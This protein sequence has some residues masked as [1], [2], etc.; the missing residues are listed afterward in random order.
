MNLLSR[1]RHKYKSG[2]R[3]SAWLG[4]ALAALVLALPWA[5]AAGEPTLER[6][7]VPGEI[8]VGYAPGAE[9]YSA[10][11]VRIAGVG[12]NLGYHPTLHAFHVR[13]HPGVSIETALAQMRRQPGVLYA[14]PV[15]VLHALA[16][17]NDPSFGSQWAPTKIQANLAW[18]I[19]QP[20]ASVVI[21]MVDSGVDGTHPDLVNK[22]YRDANGIVGYNAFQ[23]A[24]STAADDNGHGTHCA[25]IAAAQA[26][27]GIGIAGI[28]GWNGV[29][30]VSDT[31]HI[32]IMPIKAL[33]S[34]GSGTDVTAANGI[35]WAANNGAKVISMS[36]GMSSYSQTL[37]NACQFAISKGCVVVA[38]AGNNGSNALFYPA[39]DANVISV[40]ATDSTDTLASFS[41]YG[42]W[43]SVA[44]PGN[45]IYSTTP[46]YATSWPLNY[47]YGSGTSMATPHVAGEAALLLA[48]NPT[49]TPAQVAALIT[50]NVDPCKAYGTHAL[51]AAAGR[52][53]VYRALQAAAG[54]SSSVPAAPTGL[55]ATA[56]GAQVGLNWVST[57]N[58]STYNIKRATTSGGPYTT[59]KSG[60]TST[61]TTDTGLTNGVG[62]YYVVSASNAAGES[63]NSTEAYARPFASLSTVALNPTTVTGGSASQGTVTLNSA[64]PSGG[65]AVTLS[66][67]N[68]AAATTPASVTVAAGATSATF[69]ISTTKV[70]A[71]ASASISAAAGSVT[72]S[73]ALTVQAASPSVQ[74]VTI[75]PVS[76]TGGT[77]TQGTVTLSGAAPSGGMAV[78][79]SSSNTAAAS[80]P[81]SVTVAAGATSATFTVTTK[82]VTANT[83]VTITATGGGASKSAALTVNAPAV[84]SSVVTLTPAADSYVQ[85][86]SS[87]GLNFG[88]QGQLVDKRYDAN[89][90]NPYSRAVYIM[91]DLS[92]VKT[93]PTQAL[94]NLT[95]A[96][97]SSPA[98]WTKVVNLYAISDTTWTE[99]G[100]TWNNAP[101]LNRT[102][103]TSTGTL[104][105]SKTI[106]MTAG[107]VSYDIT[108]Y[109][110]AHLGQ[111]ITLQLIDSYVNNDLL[112][113]QSKEAT[114]GQPTLTLSN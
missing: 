36:F 87:A 107:V 70:S 40:A 102:N 23:N 104:L 114:S 109:V 86:G 106:A 33:Y 43:I 112:C 3:A 62:Y 74:S 51:G 58:A 4:L 80:T 93:A 13:L 42:S 11:Q 96:S 48:Q 14:E 85:S 30:G 34:T 111:K 32:Q 17:P 94:L 10:P 113:F 47:A 39:A 67:S 19:W 54:T 92:S 63:P 31:T 61:S 108:A 71:N 7:T 81:A 64:A 2:L 69:T 56:G 100:I 45:L 5:R 75:N 8:V 110:A 82:T 22:M 90:T 95:V 12:D 76:T 44:A 60:V 73:A 103:F 91:L 6:D 26:D 15:H 53:N 29:A 66:S 105:A 25:G 27:N 24:R 52:I 16:T 46:T 37:D 38:A 79:L 97:N 1:A 18:G 78:T 55:V 65:F 41:E 88:S 49:L 89:S 57:A 21:A 99:S 28:A 9:F 59:I 83:S 77:S 84:K 68:T 50:A 35:V 101:G 98:G 72:K 20:K